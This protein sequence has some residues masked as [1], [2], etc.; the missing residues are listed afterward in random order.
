MLYVALELGAQLSWQISWQ[1]G[2]SI[3]H[4]EGPSLEQIV[5]G[6]CNGWSKDLCRDKG[7]QGVLGQAGM[8][9][10]TVG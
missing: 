7:W 2:V 1:V 5:V 9:P 3:V 4:R 10:R 8:R 6:G